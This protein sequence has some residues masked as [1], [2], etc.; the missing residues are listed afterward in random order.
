M[1]DALIEIAFDGVGTSG[2]APGRGDA[3]D[4]RELKKAPRREPF[5]NIFVRVRQPAHQA[6]GVDEEMA[7]KTRKIRPYSHRALE[8]MNS[9][10]PWSRAE[11]AALC[12]DRQHA[13]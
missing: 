3:Y 4:K 11:S 9:Y 5:L 1:G 6:D 2:Y 8:A 12:G 13:A 10:S 7:I